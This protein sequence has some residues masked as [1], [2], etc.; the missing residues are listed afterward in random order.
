MG[1]WKVPPTTTSR[2]TLPSPQPSEAPPPS[3]WAPMW[4]T[5]PR[6]TSSLTSS[7]SRT[8]P[9]TSKAVSPLAHPRPWA[10]WRL[11]PWR[12]SSTR[13][14]PAGSIKSWS[15][16][17]HVYLEHSSRHVPRACV[18]R[19]SIAHAPDS[20]STHGPESATPSGLG[21]AKAHTSMKSPSFTRGVTDLISSRLRPHYWTDDLP[22]SF[23]YNF[24]F[25][26]STNLPSSPSPSSSPPFPLPY[27]RLDPGGSRSFLQENLISRVMLR[28]CV[29]VCAIAHY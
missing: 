23:G 1:G 5:S 29:C 9:R 10:S 11:R 21:S 25:V 16:T 18:D 14:T 12:T 2:T 24:D 28:A 26:L 15:G 17:E 4:P 20:T 27:F 22:P 8:A 7:A 13:R 6:R 3:S 19:G